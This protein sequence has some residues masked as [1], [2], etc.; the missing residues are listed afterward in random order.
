MR[1]NGTHTPDEPR[2]DRSRPEATEPSG[3]SWD[4]NTFGVFAMLAEI[5]MSRSHET[6]AGRPAEIL[7]RDKE[8]E[9]VEESDHRDS[10]G[11]IAL[12]CDMHPE[13]EV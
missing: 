13:C 10:H 3:H 9:E 4:Q 5:V 7:R 1:Q 8:N 6:V 12:F 2:S 11:Q